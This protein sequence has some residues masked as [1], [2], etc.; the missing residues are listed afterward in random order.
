MGIVKVPLFRGVVSH[1]MDLSDT[2]LTC[3]VIQAADL[4]CL[5]YLSVVHVVS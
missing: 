1:I 5:A 3:E 4:L 2:R